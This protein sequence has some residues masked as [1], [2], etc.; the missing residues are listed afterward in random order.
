MSHSGGEDGQHSIQLV[1]SGLLA[2]ELRSGRLK[3]LLAFAHA[4]LQQTCA[5]CSG[6]EAA[7][8]EVLCY[9][10]RCAQAAHCCTAIVRTSSRAL[11]RSSCSRFCVMAPTDRACA[12]AAVRWSR[13]LLLSAATSASTEAV[14]RD[15]ADAVSSTSVIARTRSCSTR[16]RVPACATLSVPTPASAVS[17]RG[18]A[19]SGP[20]S[21]DAFIQGSDPDT[22]ASEDGSGSISASPHVRR[23]LKHTQSSTSVAAC[24]TPLQTPGEVT[25]ASENECR[26]LRLDRAHHAAGTR[27][28]SIS[29]LR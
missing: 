20:G 21:S 26:S 27:A 29:A 3:R 23:W 24:T 19:R 17:K 6:A 4:D 28:P 25:D 22:R 7:G 2:H 16:V 11:Q 9:R 18:L 14:H 1:T 12:C 13:R 8:A 10:P 15:T 5:K